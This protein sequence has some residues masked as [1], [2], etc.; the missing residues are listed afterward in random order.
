MTNI[1]KTIVF[2]GSGP[3]AAASLE[4]LAQK[5]KIEAVVT[6]AK[7]LYH[8]HDAP[9]ESLAN[10]L[11]LPIIFASNKDELDSYVIN[12][13]FISDLGIVVD[14]GVI[15]SKQTIDSFKLGI[16]NSHFSLLPQWRG[17]DPITYSILSGQKT[18]GV[19]LMLIEPTLDTGKLFVQK[20]LDIN[21]DD[22][23]I[24]LTEK[25]INLSND[26]LFEYIPKYLDGLVTAYDQ[27]NQENASYSKKIA[28]EDSRINPAKAAERLEREVRAYFGWPGSKIS[29]KD[30]DLIIKK[31]HV[32]SEPQTKLDV[33]CSDKQYLIVDEIIA[34]S[35]KKMSANAFLNGNS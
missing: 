12:H 20:E 24:S 8:R 15:I 27:P 21:Y 35:G 7:P 11:N 14:Y 4:F 33:L 3:V 32:S 28:K 17:A 31:A 9:V 30:N 6:K 1:S 5:F 19:S 26:L 16:I 34:P 29:Y 18:T 13:P 10:K 22:T 25:L 2:F 23:T